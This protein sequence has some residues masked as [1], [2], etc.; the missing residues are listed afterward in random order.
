MSI[1]YVVCFDCLMI[2]DL[3]WLDCLICSAAY[4]VWGCLSGGFV[5][6]LIVRLCLWVLRLLVVL[7]LD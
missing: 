3:R 1:F 5:C 4:L 7:L 2:V 6:A